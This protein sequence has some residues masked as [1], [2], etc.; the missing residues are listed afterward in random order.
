[1]VDISRIILDQAFCSSSYYN[2]IT[3]FQVSESTTPC[4]TSISWFARCC[5]SRSHIML[6][7]L[8]QGQLPWWD[9]IGCTFICG[10][11]AEKFRHWLFQELCKPQVFILL[12]QWHLHRCGRGGERSI[13]HRRNDSLVYLLML[14]IKL[15]D[16]LT[17]KLITGRQI[18]IP[19][20]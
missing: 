18:N 14:L 10:T 19:A 13:G 16:N 2:V 6:L 15:P 5:Y 20:R 7:V 4:R 3:M 9:L 1:M 12:K 8:E 17:G 11:G